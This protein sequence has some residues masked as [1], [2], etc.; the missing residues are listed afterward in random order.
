MAEKFGI[1][2]ILDKAP[3]PSVSS[4][5][6]RR[7]FGNEAKRDQEET[8]ALYALAA[9]PNPYTPIELGTTISG[10][11]DFSPEPIYGY[12]CNALDQIIRTE[13]YM[14]ECPPPPPTMTLKEFADYRNFLRQRQY[15]LSDH[16]RIAGLFCDALMR[17]FKALAEQLPTTEETTPFTIPLVNAL[18]HPGAMISGMHK[19]LEEDVYRERGLFAS[20]INRLHVNLCYASAVEPYKD[21]R[22]PYKHAFE[23]DLPLDRLSDTYLSET[24]LLDLF[25]NRC[26]SNSRTKSVSATCMSWVAPTRA[27]PP[28]SKTLSCTIWRSARRRA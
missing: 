26:R 12:L 11:F 17:I 1:I 15:F 8:Q 23:S 22:R 13:R 20:L 25:S 16:D 5:F 24:P 2:R 3:G 27:R 18:P 19:V 10:V 6:F 28:S 4:P 9:Q 7:F 14:F 21:T